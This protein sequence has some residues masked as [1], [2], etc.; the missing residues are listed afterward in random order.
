VR[1]S[2]RC[3]DDVVIDTNALGHAEQPL[4]AFHPSALKFLQWMSVTE[5][6]KWILDDNGK[7]APD[8]KTSVLASE[9]YETLSPQGLPLTLFTACLAMGRVAFATRPTPSTRKIIR[10]LVPRNTNDQAVLGATTTCK[11]RVLISN[12]YNDFSDPVRVMCAQELGVEV[13]DTEQAVA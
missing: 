3:V 8:L 4:V 10:R 13:M 2:S 11:D 6:V 12:D 5:Q 9:Y 7:S 1:T